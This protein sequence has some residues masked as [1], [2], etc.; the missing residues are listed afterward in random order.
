MFA[1][2]RT[3]HSRETH[4]FDVLGNSGFSIIRHVVPLSVILHIEQIV[5]TTALGFAKHIPRVWTGAR[6]LLFCVS[7][8]K[9][10]CSSAERPS[11]VPNVFLSERGSA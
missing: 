5:S 6:S 4:G 10:H 8:L 11:S 3:C 2:D 7:V 9:F 1:K